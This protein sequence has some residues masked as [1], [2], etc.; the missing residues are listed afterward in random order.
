MRSMSCAAASLESV[1]PELWVLVQL[2]LFA[3]KHEQGTLAEDDRRWFA[4]FVR[5]GHKGCG[6]EQ[7]PGDHVVK[8]RG[9]CGCQRDRAL[10]D[11][12]KPEQLVGIGGRP[13]LGADVVE[14]GRLL[15]AT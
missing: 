3:W 9:L 15:A 2:R 13:V 8:E 5:H 14:W 10:K 1:T 4:L 12:Y 6:V 7:R 11:P